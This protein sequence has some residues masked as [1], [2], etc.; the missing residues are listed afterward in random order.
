MLE[1]VGE[2]AVR[3]TDDGVSVSVR[4]WASWSAS[5]SAAEGK[6]TFGTSPTRSWGISGASR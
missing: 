2:V 1:H 5:T 3:E 6:M 4:V